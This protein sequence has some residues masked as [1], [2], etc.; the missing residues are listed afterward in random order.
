[1]N[2]LSDSFSR[3]IADDNEVYK[4]ESRNL[5]SSSDVCLYFEG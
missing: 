3:S 1:M 2:G 4:N 5:R